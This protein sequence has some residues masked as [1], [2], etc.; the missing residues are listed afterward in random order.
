MPFISLTPGLEQYLREKVES[1]QYHSIGEVVRESLGM[2]QDRDAWRRVKLQALRE[3]I[4]LGLDD[5]NNG[6][7]SKFDADTII[8][9][10]KLGRERLARIQE[11]R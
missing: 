5:L 7:A 8:T 4:K 2:M 3:E 11:E 1:G 9:V 10:K 6:Q